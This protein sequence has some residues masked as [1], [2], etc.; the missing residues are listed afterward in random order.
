MKVLDK[1]A[2]TCKFCHNEEGLL[3][4]SGIIYTCIYCEKEQNFFKDWSDYV[5][6]CYPG[7]D[8]YKCISKQDQAIIEY[9]LKNN[10]LENIKH[11]INLYMDY[12]RRGF[13]YCGALLCEE[14]NYL[15]QIY[16]KCIYHGKLD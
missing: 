12:R 10:L 13:C 16:K 3:L 8:V 1:S 11:L 5:L 14:Y 6:N 9:C 15:G 2:G 4:Q 7:S